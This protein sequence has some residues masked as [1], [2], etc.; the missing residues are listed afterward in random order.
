[1]VPKP[2]IDTSVS[3]GRAKVLLE[4]TISMLMKLV[5]RGN[6]KG[7]FLV[8]KCMDPGLEKR[9]GSTPPDDTDAQITTD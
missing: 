5:S 6:H 4:I 1:M 9:S 7:K 3:V 2:E 8:Y